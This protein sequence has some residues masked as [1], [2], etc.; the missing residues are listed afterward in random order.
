MEILDSTGDTKVMWDRHNAAEVSI[1]RAAFDAA[2]AKG[3]SI[4]QVKGKNGD[5]G[6]RLTEFDPD[7]ERMIVVPQMVGG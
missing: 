4:F 3:A 6:K 2:R 5:R 7:V 1:A